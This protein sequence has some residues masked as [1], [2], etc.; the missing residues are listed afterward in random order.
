MRVI[1][2]C[3]KWQA[4]F[5]VWTVCNFSVAADGPS[6]KPVL[7]VPER[8]CAA[9]ISA[10]GAAMGQTRDWFDLPTI[11]ILLKGYWTV[12]NAQRIGHIAMNLRG[13]QRERFTPMALEGLEHFLDQED[14]F[15]ILLKKL[16]DF[17]LIKADKLDPHYARL[18][19]AG[20]NPER[21]VLDEPYR[22]VVTPGQ[23]PEVD[24][25][26]TYYLQEV[27]AL[28]TK[29][30][31][32]RAAGT[33]ARVHFLIEEL[34][35][36]F[37]Q[38]GD[39]RNSENAL[40]VFF[41]EFERLYQLTHRVRRF[42]PEDLIF[43]R[44]RWVGM[45][46]AHAEYIKAKPVIMQ[47]I[48]ESVLDSIFSSVWGVRSVYGLATKAWD[49]FI[50]PRRR[51]K[52][53]TMRVEDA[54][55]RRVE[56][57]PGTQ[58]LF[59][60]GHDPYGLTDEM[61]R[62]YLRAA[63]PSLATDGE[64]QLDLFSP[65]FLEELI[66]VSPEVASL[67]SSSA[68]IT[69]KLA[70]QTTSRKVHGVFG[71]TN[72]ETHRAASRQALGFA[73]CRGD[74]SAFQHALTGSDQPVLS[75][76]TA[77]SLRTQFLSDLHISDDLIHF[78]F[79]DMDR[80]FVFL[81]L[82]AIGRSQDE[83]TKVMDE[84]YQ[85]SDRF[86]S[87]YER[88]AFDL[89][90][91][92]PHQSPHFVRQE[93]A[94]EDNMLRVF[95]YIYTFNA[96][97]LLL[98]EASRNSLKRMTGITPLQVSMLVWRAFLSYAAIPNLKQGTVKGTA[99]VYDL[100]ARLYL[101]LRNILMNFAQ[102]TFDANKAYWA[103]L[104]MRAAYLQVDFPDKP[105]ST[106]EFDPRVT[107]IRLA[108]QSDI[109]ERADYDELIEEF[110]KL[111]EREKK[112]LHDFHWKYPTITYFSADLRRVLKRKTSSPKEGARIWLKF[113]A[114]M[115]ADVEDE[116]NFNQF[117]RNCEYDGSEIRVNLRDVLRYLDKTGGSP[118]SLLEV[119]I[120]PMHGQDTYDIMVDTDKPYDGANGNGTN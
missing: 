16:L 95:Q 81:F 18:V 110:E 114:R 64:P 14:G 41:T 66:R 28:T 99:L 102:G 88:R 109:F 90:S 68:P 69:Q 5:L 47:W 115:L 92:Y 70:A 117:L 61:R 76:E 12:P 83:F 15:R 116:D 100:I 27:L 101:G 78:S 17:K 89:L 45:L 77:H 31:V 26:V 104:Q 22:R 38:L 25:V 39:N 32:A 24:P 58:T 7:V 108:E 6:Q 118:E 20:D 98:G 80:F 62:F 93:E 54:N 60:V 85:L 4:L 71:P 105:I 35:Q 48:G 120:H 97:Q 65:E 72:F 112:V 40:I 113:M 67:E 49:Y 79:P 33:F 96:G 59:L 44:D 87:D 1:M 46:D 91:R 94:E 42:S 11:V 111:S 57:L 9:D 36:I 74:M 29:Q 53:Q 103:I 106:E 21:L 75:D 34:K 56:M 3:K 8:T 51:A 10:R 55:P 19:L 107:Y 119:P 84:Y 82:D 37:S 2:E 43:Y 23:E 86:E 13:N 63:L 52:R 30:K 50:E 73:L